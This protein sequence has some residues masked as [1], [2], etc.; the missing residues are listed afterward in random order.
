M[1]LSAQDFRQSR[2]VTCHDRGFR[3]ACGVGHGDVLA[4]HMPH[5]T[6]TGVVPGG[7]LLGMAEVAVTRSTERSRRRENSGVLPYP[8]WLNAGDNAW[9]L[10]AA[11]LVGLMSVPGLVLLYGGVV[12]KKWAINTMLMAFTGFCIVLFVWVFYGFKMG[13]GTPAHLF[14]AGPGAFLSN[15]VGQPGP[16][17][18]PANEIGQAHI[19]LIS[20]VGLMPKFRFGQSSL[21]YF[22][23]VFAAITPLLFLG[24]VLTRMSLKAWMIFVFL[25]ASLVYPINAFLLWGGGYFAQQGAVDYS[26][27]YVIHLAAGVSG[28][29]AAAVL[30]P[31]IKGDR[32]STPNNMMF[33]ALGAGLLWL[34]WNGF[35]GGDPYFAGA[36]A[37]AAVLNTN[38]AAA[39]AMFIW[40]IWDMLSPRKSASLIGAVNGMI[41]GLVGITPAAGFVNGYG[42][43]II[44]VGGSSIVWVMMTYVGPKIPFFNRVDDALG[45]V[46]THGLAGLIGGLSVGLLADPHMMMYLGASGTATGG[47]SVTS[48]FYGSDGGNQIYH[49]FQAA[50]WIIL[51][52]SI[53]TFIILRVMKLFMPLRYTDQECLDGDIAIH[54]EQVTADFIG[55]QSLVAPLAPPPGLGD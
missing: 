15:L 29:V 48:L 8:A 22:Q 38:L 42:A 33:V 26:G 17:L 10:T 32:E 45:V 16:V 36:D 18:S 11:T 40:V 3:G 23:F 9:Q 51:F 30:G 24:S 46:Y 47:F 7:Q 21:I 55:E 20:D 12:Q 2:L 52:S 50:V 49:Q 28:F 31:R 1:G 34:G 5:P 14:G 41:V 43:L 6:P 4:S 39:S 27:G 54:G 19:P 13:F 37:G 44:G 53:M 25:W 35:N